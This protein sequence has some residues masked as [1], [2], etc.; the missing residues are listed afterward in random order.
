MFS[1]GRFRLFVTRS[2]HTIVSLSSHFFS[3]LSRV[4][5]ISLPP[6][7]FYVVIQALYRCINSIFNAGE[8]FLATFSQSTSSVGCKVLCIFMTFLVPWSINWSSSLVHI[9]NGPEYV[10]W[11]A[12]KVFIYWQDFFYVVWFP[13][14][15]FVLMTYFLKNIFLSSPHVWWCP[16]SIFPSICSFLLSLL[17]LLLLLLFNRLFLIPRIRYAFVL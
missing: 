8:S 3:E 4:A 10:T 6:D 16:L 12:A 5:V 1:R 14:V 7:F 2:V 11:G 17:L 15:F 13:V 9:E